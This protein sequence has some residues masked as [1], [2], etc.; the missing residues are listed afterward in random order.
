M[1][2]SLHLYG[3]PTSVL[4]QGAVG[5]L[6][7]LEE[8]HLEYVPELDKVI[9]WFANPGAELHSDRR[10]WFAPRLS[11]LTIEAEPY[12]VPSKELATLV[13]ERFDANA[14]GLEPSRIE[15][16]VVNEQDML[17]GASPGEVAAFEKPQ[18][19]CGRK[20]MWIPTSQ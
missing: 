5:G 9:E 4:V 15:R 16:L 6:R 1:L 19:F 13:K 8:L 3:F 12:D 11:S 14:G 18:R 2:R 20:I 10:S 17:R 7:N